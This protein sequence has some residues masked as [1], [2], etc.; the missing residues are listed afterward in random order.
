MKTFAVA[1]LA[2]SAVADYYD[3]HADG[4]HVHHDHNDGM[5]SGMDMTL[6]NFSE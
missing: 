2:S 4:G 6:P 3:D 5:A 1:L